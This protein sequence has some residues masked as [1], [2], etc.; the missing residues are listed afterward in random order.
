MFWWILKQSLPLSGFRPLSKIFLHS[1][2]FSDPI[3]SFNMFWYFCCKTRYYLLLRPEMTALLTNKSCL[4]LLAR[5]NVRNMIMFCLDHVLGNKKFMWK[6]FCSS[7]W[8][9]HRDY[10]SPNESRHTDFSQLLCDW[11][12][13]SELVKLIKC[14]V[15]TC[16]ERRGALIKSGVGTMRTLGLVM[17]VK[18][19]NWLALGMWVIINLHAASDWLMSGIPG[20]WLADGLLV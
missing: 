14:L 7:L 5:A 20:F 10:V 3:F 6:I 1:N 16:E 2:N 18:K 19:S 9:W 4:S 11:C 15:L 13:H 12:F 17:G 8:R